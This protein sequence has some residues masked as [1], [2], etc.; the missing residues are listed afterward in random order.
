MRNNNTSLIGSSTC[1]IISF[2][3]AYL[4]VRHWR[5]SLAALAIGAAVIA[6]INGWIIAAAAAALL[7]VKAQT[8]D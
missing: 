7:L 6:G 2:A 1:F 4:L 3:S 8:G 5:L